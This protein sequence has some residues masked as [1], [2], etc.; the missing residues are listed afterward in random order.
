VTDEGWRS[1]VRAV[2]TD[3]ED[4]VLML[5]SDDGPALP[6]VDLEG[7]A[8]DAVEEPRRA[9]GELLGT[10][11]A[12]LR[13]LLR[14]LDREQRLLDVAY[15]LEVLDP[16]WKPRP[17]AAWRE[18]QALRGDE[19]DL[20]ASDERGHVPVTRAP[21]AREGWLAEATAWIESSLAMLCRPVTGRAEQVRAWPLS[22]VLRVPADDGLVYFKATSRSP[23]FVDEG[24]VMQG[25]AQLFRRAV[26]EPLAVDSA[27]RW[28]LLED[29]GAAV[30]WDAPLDERESV[31]RVFAFMQVASSDD[32]EALFAM[33]CVDRR[34]AWLARETTLLLEDDEA[35][36][37]L[38]EHERARLRSLEPT[39][40]ALCARLDEG[41]VPD[42]LVHGDLHLD[43]IARVGGSYVFFDWTDACVTHPFLD[44]IDVHREENPAVRERL[45]DAYL[46]IW[47][48]FASCERL[49]T[50]WKLSTPLASLNQAVSYRHIVASVEPGSIQ[51]LEWA[52]PHWLR[53]V[54]ATDFDSL[55]L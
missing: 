11:V 44:L 45:R 55:P 28:M 21:W 6:A 52:L 16:D 17:G 40:A 9:L 36:A 35:L 39:L 14:S 24:R 53:L 1:R 10:D 23:L 38:E 29:V 31:L 43:N 8:E 18:R 51:Q 49:L 27:R 22:A 19:R 15:A 41:E 4:R 2:V 46:S 37:G 32:L 25:L 54:P 48:D 7:F 12:I 42:A 34:P 50:L 33:G 30:G 47:S 20:V 13:Y 5:E 3:G 26:P